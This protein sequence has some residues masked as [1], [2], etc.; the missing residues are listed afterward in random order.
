MSH[1]GEII[2]FFMTDNVSNVE[3]YMTCHVGREGNQ[4]NELKWVL[5]HPNPCECTRVIMGGINMWSSIRPSVP[6]YADTPSL[7]DDVK[8]IRSHYELKCNKE[9]KNY[10]DVLFLR[11][12]F[13]F[14]VVVVVVFN[15]NMGIG[16]V[17]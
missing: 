17:F 12:Y 16:Q 3:A 10:N 13:C 6:T 15:R 11:F 14:V 7:S 4:H 5:S 8:A 2:I 9:S 1:Y